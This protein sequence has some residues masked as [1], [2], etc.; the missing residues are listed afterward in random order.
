MDNPFVQG[1]LHVGP[2]DDSLVATKAGLKCHSG[3]REDLL[4]AGCIW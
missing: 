4:R 1:Y 3:D 2:R